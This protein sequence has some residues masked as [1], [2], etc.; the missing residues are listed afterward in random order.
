MTS[1][2]KFVLRVHTLPFCGILFLYALLVSVLNQLF[3]GGYFSMYYAA[4]PLFCIIILAMSAI[5]LGG[6]HMNLALSMGACRRD[7]CKSV[8]ADI[9]LTTLFALTL[10]TVLYHFQTRFP[11]ASPPLLSVE[12]AK[13]S[14]SV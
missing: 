8:H 2:L 10:H 11:R 7:Y 13:Y 9:L 5:S 4:F 1:A 3:P 14:F 12:P 6:V